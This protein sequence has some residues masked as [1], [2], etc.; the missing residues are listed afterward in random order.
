ML[1]KDYELIDLGGTDCVDD[2]TP[3]G[4]GNEVKDKTELYGNSSEFFILQ[5]FDEQKKCCRILFWLFFSVPLV[6]SYI[7][8]TL[9]MM[10]GPVKTRP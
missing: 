9:Y 8:R 1:P 5:C 2:R 6:C 4:H 3:L 10:F 7:H